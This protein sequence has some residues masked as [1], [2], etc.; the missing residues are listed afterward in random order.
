MNRRILLA[1][2]VVALFLNSVNAGEKYA[3]VVGVTE[4]EHPKFKTLKYAENDV[5]KLNVRDRWLGRIGRATY[6][7]PRSPASRV[8]SRAR[9]NGWVPKARG[10]GTCKPPRLSRRRYRLLRPVGQTA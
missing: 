6:A 5:S 1:T 3:L 2:A 10:Q 8:I 4:Y 7:F 9:A